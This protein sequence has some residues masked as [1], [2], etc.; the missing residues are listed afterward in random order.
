MLQDLSAVG[1][2]VREVQVGVGIDQRHLHTP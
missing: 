2:E 1:V